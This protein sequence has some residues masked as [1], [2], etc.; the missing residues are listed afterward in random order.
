LIPSTAAGFALF[1]LLLAPGLAF[2]LRHE[3]VVPAQSYSAF[4]ETLRV[5]FVSVACL[6]TAGL[7]FAALRWAL[8]RYTLDVRAFVQDPAGFAK[9][10]HVSVAWWS[11]AFIGYATLI[12]AVAADPRVLERLWSWRS[13]MLAQ[14]LLG[15]TDGRIRNLSAWDRAMG[16]LR[17]EDA[18]VFAGVQMVDGSYVQGYVASYSPRTSDDENR[19]LLLAAPEMRTA[20]GKLHPLGATLTVISARHIQRLDISHIL[21]DQAAPPIGGQRTGD[22]DR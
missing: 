3:R 22:P 10:H 4:R 6:V 2:V 19:D 17:P 18:R 11:L 20:D 8:P 14:A 9:G 13:K 5:V 15:S 21:D 12:G 7:A 1:V 16:E